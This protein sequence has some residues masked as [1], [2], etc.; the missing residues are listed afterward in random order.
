MR[1]QL[2]ALA[3]ASATAVAAVIGNGRFFFQIISGIMGRKLS[4][5]RMFDLVIDMLS[6]SMGTWS[7]RLMVAYT[8]RVA[9]VLV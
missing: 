5:R 6:V 4:V 9:L 1:I 7:A 2:S 3:A 8:F